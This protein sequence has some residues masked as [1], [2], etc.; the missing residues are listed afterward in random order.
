[1][2]DIIKNQQVAELFIQSTACNTTGNLKD[3]NATD[4]AILKFL[5]KAGI[6]FEEKRDYHLPEGFVR[7]QF[8]SK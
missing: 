5:N 6:N 7:F 8:T 3:S 2:G 1:M 4:L